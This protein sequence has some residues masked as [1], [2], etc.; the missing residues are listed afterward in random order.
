MPPEE[1]EGRAENVI[2]QVTIKTD[3]SSKIYIG[4]GVNQLKKRIAIFNT[5]INSKPNDRNYFQYKQAAE[6]SKLTHKLKNE[7]KN[8]K[9]TWKIIKKLINL[10]Q[11]E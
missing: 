7:N 4:I 10:N 6:L 5:T 9:L 8:Y 2:N 11:E 3:S 1:G